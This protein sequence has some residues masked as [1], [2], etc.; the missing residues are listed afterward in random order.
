MKQKWKQSVSLFLSICMLITMLS[1][2]AFAEAFE[3]DEAINPAAELTVLISTASTGSAITGTMDIGGQENISLSNNAGD[4]GTKGWSWDA[5][6]ATLALDGSYSSTDGINIQCGDSDTIYLILEGDVT[7]QYDSLFVLLCSGNLNI[8][9]GDYTLNLSSSTYWPAIGTNGLT[10]ESGTL[11]AAGGDEANGIQASGDVTIS[12]SANVTA[13]SPGGSGIWGASGIMSMG[14][15]IIST[16]GKVHTSGYK[17]GIYAGGGITI[18]SGTVT[19]NGVSPAA[20]IGHNNGVTFTGGTLT[21]NTTGDANGDVMGG[22]TVSGADANVTINGNIKHLLDWDDTTIISPGNLTV[23]GGNVAVNGT[24]EGTTTH[25]G[26]TLNGNSLEVISYGLTVGGVTVTDANKDNI[27]GKGIQGKVSYNSGTKTLTLD[28]AV[29]APSSIGSGEEMNAIQSMDDLK[30]ILMGSNVLGIK[31]DNP[32]DGND[33]AIAYGIIAG[34]ENITV[35]GDGNLTIYD[36]R[37]GIEAKNITVDI[38]GILTV[39]E[40]GIE[41]KACCLKADGGTL[42]IIRGTLNLTSQVS[43]GLYGDE[44]V[45]NCADI[46]AYSK[47]SDENFAFN[48]APTFGKGYTYRVTAGDSP[49]SAKLV[50]SPAAK[51]FTANR[52]VKIEATV[53]DGNKDKEDK[54][55][56]G[57]PNKPAAPDVPEEKPEQPAAPAAKFTDISNHWGRES[58]EY[59]A[60]LGLLRGTSETAFAPDMVMSR[61]MLVAALGRLSG[62]NEDD[63]NTNSFI[64]VKYESAFRPYIEWAYNKGIIKGIGNGMFAPDRA[65]TREEIAVIFVNYAE[66]E[67]YTLPATGEVSSFADYEQIGDAYKTAAAA[68]QQAGIMIGDQNKMFNPK[69]DTTRAEASAML[70]RYVKAMK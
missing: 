5:A 12:G 6:T 56:G 65:I 19:A 29:I 30:V 42:N 26:G 27:A 34:G 70:H 9:A 48:K 58:I 23:S 2:A 32:A 37:A 69:S 59:V 67:G 11:I 36:L 46:T 41:G 55:N 49:E 10:I 33:Y 62:I 4:L 31:P 68:M 15:V 3:S 21:T 43:N 13:I 53:S 51:T 50:S 45:I 14:D 66:T 47:E 40:Y 63:Y 52:Y 22:L 17:N 7:I 1:V 60:A 25:T 28:N 64:D 61:G 8:D 54:D 18:E 20:L 16:S 57:S 44:I 39:Q 35:T 38:G 24:V